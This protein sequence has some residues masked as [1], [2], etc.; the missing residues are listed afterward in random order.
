MVAMDKYVLVFPLF[1]AHQTNDWYHN[2]GSKYSIASET[3]TYAEGAVKCGEKNASLVTIDE[4]TEF[5]FLKQIINQAYPSS[6]GLFL[7]GKCQSMR[8][9][10][11]AHTLTATCYMHADPS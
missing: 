6:Q 9:H 10:T 1:S 7:L 11:Q 2:Q 3:V 4:W 5:E 8:A